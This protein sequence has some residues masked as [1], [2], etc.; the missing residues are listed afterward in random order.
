MVHTGIPVGVAFEDNQV[1]TEM[2]LAA[3]VE[4]D[5]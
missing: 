5:L 3:L 1:G 2:A 4:N